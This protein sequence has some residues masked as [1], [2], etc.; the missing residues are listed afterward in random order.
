MA[1]VIDEAPAGNVIL[2]GSAPEPSVVVTFL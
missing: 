2:C 1:N